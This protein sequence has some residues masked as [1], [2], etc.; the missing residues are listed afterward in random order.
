MTRCMN[1]LCDRWACVRLDGQWVY[2]FCLPCWFHS[3]GRFT[4]FADT[5]RGNGRTE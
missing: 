4:L 1:G 3:R 5:P 2:W